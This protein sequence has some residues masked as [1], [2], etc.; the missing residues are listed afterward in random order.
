[1]PFKLQFLSPLV[2]GLL[3]SILFLFDDI[4]GTVLLYL[5]LFLYADR[6]SSGIVVFFYFYTTGDKSLRPPV[7]VKN[8]GLWWCIKK[9]YMGF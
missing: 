1:M 9:N 6:T 3:C 2:F 8:S 4:L 5:I 7:I